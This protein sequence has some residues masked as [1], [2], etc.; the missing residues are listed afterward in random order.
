MPELIIKY[1]HPK[2]KQALTDFSKYLNFTIVS[3]TEKADKRKKEKTALI[4]QIEKGLM[5]VK[6]IREGKI[7]GV[8]VKE[9]LDG[10]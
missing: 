4:E 10:K 6:K 5:D 8:S 1:K 9:M 7:K 3:K 2:V